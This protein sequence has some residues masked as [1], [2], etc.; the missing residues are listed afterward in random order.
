MVAIV[1]ADNPMSI[2]AANNIAKAIRR[3]ERN[4]T[5]L[6]GVIA[7]NIRGGTRTWDLDAFAQLLDT[8]VLA[9]IP[10]DQRILDAEADRVPVCERAPE[11]DLGQLF[12]ALAIRL[13]EIEPA[14][15]PTPQPLDDDALDDFFRLASAP[16]EPE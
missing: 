7:N 11:S 12:T 13:Q 6:A 14:Q 16:S 2:Y 15:C 3:F 8:T 5:H 10:H 4:G 9:R 1:V